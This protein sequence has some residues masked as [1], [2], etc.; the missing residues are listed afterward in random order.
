MP[1]MPAGTTAG[2]M[3]PAFRAAADEPRIVE[4]A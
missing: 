4:A 3:P 2:R 1:L